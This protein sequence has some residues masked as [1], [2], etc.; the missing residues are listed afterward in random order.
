MDSQT[1]F[2]NLPFKT[3][4]TNIMH[5]DI[6]SCFATIE[7]QANPR[8]RYKPLVVA[9]YASK[10]G[11]ILAASI[12]AKKDY[13]IKTGMRVGDA[14][15]L[16][17]NILVLS[18][19]PDKYRFVHKQ[20]RKIL[21][22]YTP[23]PVPKSIDEFVCD[24]SNLPIKNHFSMNQIGEKIKVDIKQ[25]IGDY[26][27]VSV[28]IGPNRFLAK[29]AAG[30]IKPNGLETINSQNFLSVYEKLKLTDLC[31]IST[32]NEIRLKLKGINTV[33]DMYKSP[34]WRLKIAFGGI[35]GLYWYLRLRGWEI[36]SVDWGRKSYGNSYALP[37]PFSKVHE[38]SPILT[39]LTQKTGTR[40]RRAGYMAGGIHLA[41]YFRD[42]T[43]FAHGEKLNH[44]LYDSVDIFKEANRLLQK[45]V[46]G[47]P[48]R[49][50]AVSCFALSK[51]DHLQLN[52]FQ[53]EIRKESK[54]KAVDKINQKLGN[55]TVAPARMVLEGDK[56]LDRIAFG[57]VKEL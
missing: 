48:V 29:T 6:N 11:C 9:A 2:Q 17:P 50:I 31:G 16:C 43:Y 3:K 21:N 36:D 45:G 18:P 41:L 53:N 52:L 47:K 20:F 30:L 15:K 34:L 7:Q 22:K 35:S 13:G 5:I 46:C 49:N 38:L 27:T 1:D 14:Q 23:H 39:K 12:E 32:R 56:V 10:G 4:E 54:V 26:I 19:D 55:F 44:N 37:K 40:L 28:G 33:T 25:I 8:L 24:F 51:K 42:H 57:G